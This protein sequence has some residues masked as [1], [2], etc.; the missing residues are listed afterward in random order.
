MV[1][2]CRLFYVLGSF[3]VLGCIF[4]TSRELL[5]FFKHRKQYAA[6]RFG[7]WV[8]LP[9]QGAGAWVERAAAGCQPGAWARSAACCCP[10]M[11]FAC[12]LP[13]GVHAGVI[14]EHSRTLFR[15]RLG[16]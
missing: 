10:Q 14:L 5:G 12:V 2:E 1:L 11:S 8:L 16:R 7:A 6:V 15:L 3:H 9:L 4:P 13:F